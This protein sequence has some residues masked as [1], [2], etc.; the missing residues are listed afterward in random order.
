MIENSNDPTSSYYQKISASWELGFSDYELALT[1]DDEKNI[2]NAEIVSN[3][4]QIEALED[5]L[6]S[7]GGSGKLEDGRN[8]YRKV[9][10]DI[11]PFLVFCCVTSHLML[12]FEPLI[13]ILF[14]LAVVSLL[15][16][17]APSDKV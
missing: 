1:K 5:N 8:I 13:K 12:C 4:Q 14:V 15:F 9:V 2:E 16:I 7:L 6:R 3:A 10:N 11:V 17:I